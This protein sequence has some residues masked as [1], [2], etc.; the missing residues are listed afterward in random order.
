MVRDT[1]AQTI[2]ASSDTATLYAAPC[3]TLGNVSIPFSGTTGTQ[4]FLFPDPF[5]V[6]KLQ[7]PG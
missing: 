5:P 6:L 3:V 7:S 1:L 4:T 2:N